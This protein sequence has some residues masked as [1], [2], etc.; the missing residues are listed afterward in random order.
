MKRAKAWNGQVLLSSKVLNNGSLT[1]N[2]M[3]FKGKH[4]DVI[5]PKEKPLNISMYNVLEI[6]LKIEGNYTTI[7]LPWLFIYSGKYGGAHILSHI[8]VSGAAMKTCAIVVP[9]KPWPASKY[10]PSSITG[11]TLRLRVLSP[12]NFTSLNV[13]VN[14]KI[15][16]GNQ[17]TLCRSYLD[18]LSL[19]NIK[20]IVVNRSLSTYN[21]SYR[22]VEDS[23]GREFKVF[24]ECPLLSIYKTSLSTAPIHIV[25]PENARL[26]VLEAEPYHIK[27]KLL[28]GDNIDKV[29]VVVPML[30]S[31]ALPNPLKITVY[32]A[33][34][35][36]L[37]ATPINYDGL[38][39]YVIDLGK[40][41]ELIVD[42]TYPIKC[43]TAYLA[44]LVLNLAPLPML[45]VSA[46]LYLRM[47]VAKVER[48]E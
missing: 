31:E 9:D 4:T 25:E 24:Y 21:Q 36:Q 13:K 33:K 30:Y 18:L 40:H 38:R 42:L 5:P 28:V 2:L 39:G 34:G 12:A 32:T 19:L 44:F 41:R 8:G 22:L 6:N 1:L 27:A 48:H 35:E 37:K 43:I 23:L 46:L 20:Y 47:V 7:T 16:V 11:F 10:D 45:I 26:E 17:T 15:I 29:V 3:L 14:L